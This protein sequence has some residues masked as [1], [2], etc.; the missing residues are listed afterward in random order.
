MHAAALDTA[1]SAKVS[2]DETVEERGGPACRIRRWRP[3][4]AVS[5]SGIDLP[6]DDAASG[7]QQSLDRIGVGYW[8]DAIRVAVQDQRR[9]EA[10]R[11]P[12]LTRQVTEIVHDG[13]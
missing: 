13:F 4:E 9:R 12:E 10:A 8:N 6:L 7:L 2:A 1:A 11:G 5:L 3:T